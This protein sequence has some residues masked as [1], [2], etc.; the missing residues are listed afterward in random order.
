[1]I[2]AFRTHPVCLD[3]LA[4]RVHVV[5]ARQMREYPGKR[6]SFTGKPRAN[7]N[8]ATAGREGDGDGAALTSRPSGD[9][10]GS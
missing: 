10:R 4:Y 5:L 7:R 2:H 9:Y 3:L 6:P 1:M 8:I